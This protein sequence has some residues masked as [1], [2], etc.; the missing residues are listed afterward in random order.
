[1]MLFIKISLAIITFSL[2]GFIKLPRKE[3][4]S[5]QYISLF[6][7]TAFPGMV[8]NCVMIMLLVNIMLFNEV[9]NFWGLLIIFVLCLVQIII[10]KLIGVIIF[11]Y[12]LSRKSA[13]AEHTN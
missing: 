7:N 13:S 11:K 6:K 10:L 9:F 5:L 12:F 1:M 8:L 4:N 3:K 2:L